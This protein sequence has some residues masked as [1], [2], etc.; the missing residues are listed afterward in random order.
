MNK[1]HAFFASS[2]FAVVGATNKVEKYG[3]KVWK[4]VCALDRPCHPVHPTLPD[5]DGIKAFKSLREIPETPEAVITIT[6]PE[7]TEKIVQE[8]KQLGINKVWMQPGTESEKA[9]AFCN[10][11]GIQLVFDD[12]VIGRLDGSC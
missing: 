1:V 12:C 2:S 3:Y 11:N 10:G 6:A 8:C 7:N 4:R 9:I 5:I